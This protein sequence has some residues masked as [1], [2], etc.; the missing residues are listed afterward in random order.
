[1]SAEQTAVDVAALA[2]ADLA[3]WGVTSIDQPIALERCPECRRFLCRCE[4]GW[5]TRD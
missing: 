5:V 4:E 3:Y 2:P 1:M